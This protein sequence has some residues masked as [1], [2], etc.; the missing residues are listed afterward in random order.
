[1]ENL[2]NYMELNKVCLEDPNINHDVLYEPM[3][4]KNV[5]AR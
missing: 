2:W 3:T 1:M 4:N 5:E